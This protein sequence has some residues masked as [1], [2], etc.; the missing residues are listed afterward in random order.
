MSAQIS[1][2]PGRFSQFGEAIGSTF[3]LVTNPE[4]VDAITVNQ[5]APYERFIT[6][7]MGSGDRFEDLLEKSIPEPAPI[8]VV[9]PNRFFE[10]PDPEL[11]GQ[12]KIMGMACNSTPTSLEEIRHFLGVME[13]T[14]ASEQAAFCDTFFEIAEE[15]EKLVYV[16]PVHGTR[17]ELDHLRDGLVWNQQAGPLE[18]GDQQLVPSG[19]PDQLDH[20][21][22]RSACCRW[23]SASSTRR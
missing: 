5:T 18:W 20:L 1:I 8:L 13:R 14:S 15:S 10:S 19:G 9:S 23:R 21:P 17:A 22:A 7:P 2:D 16:D 3:C 4:L 6:V 12:R 11:V